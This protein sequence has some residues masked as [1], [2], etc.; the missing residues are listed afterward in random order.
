MVKEL[1]KEREVDMKMNVWDFIQKLE[2]EGKTLD[3]VYNE[4]SQELDRLKKYRR[5]LKIRDNTDLVNDGKRY[6]EGYLG[7]ALYLTDLDN[8]EEYVLS[9]MRTISQKKRE[10]EKLLNRCKD[11]LSL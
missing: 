4:K 10:N 11:Y 6:T 3:K 9:E 1:S 2:D 5:E 8:K 7:M